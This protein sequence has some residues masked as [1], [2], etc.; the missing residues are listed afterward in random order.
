MRLKPKMLEQSIAPSPEQTELIQIGDYNQRNQDYGRTVRYMERLHASEILATPLKSKEFLDSLSYLDFKRWIS[1]ANGIERGIPRK[2]RGQVSDSY[3]RSESSRKAVAIEYRPPHKIY[4]NFFLQTAFEKA[5][6]VDDPK[7]AGLSLGMSMNA[8]HYFSD[9]NGRM[10][11]LVFAFLT[12][13]YDGSKENQD[14]YTALLENEKGREVFNPNPA[15][16]GID[17]KIRSE[18]FERL[19]EKFGYKEAFGDIMPTSIYNSYY[20]KKDDIPSPQKLAVSDKINGLGRLMLYRILESGGM[21]MMSLMNT[22]SPERVEDFVYSSLSDSQSYVNGRDFLPTLTQE[23]VQKWMLS[24][25]LL[26][27]EYVVSLINAT[28]R[29]DIAEIAGH[30]N[31]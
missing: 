6:Q 26:I 11:R 4:R 18:M 20:G 19:Q 25:E 21:E 15:V 30:Y 8:V 27:G 12:R 3:V 1:F 7:I 5:Q 9:G 16:S 24:S 13:G 29:G 22:F 23:E 28:D 14:Y 31:I 10:A 2:K 17:K